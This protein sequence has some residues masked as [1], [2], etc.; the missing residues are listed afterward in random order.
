MTSIKLIITVGLLCLNICEIFGHGYMSNPPSRSSAWKKGFK[1]PINWDDNGL[2]CGGLT[3]QFSINKGKCGLCGDDYRMK[4]PRSNENGGKFGLGVIVATYNESQEINVTIV[5]SANHLGTFEFSLCP[6]EDEKSIE[7]EEC[8][9][10][11]PLKL[12]TGEDKYTLTSK[13][14]GLYEISLVLPEGLSCDHCTMRWHWRSANNWGT[15][16]DKK[17]QAMGC[18]AQETFRNCADIKIVKQASVEI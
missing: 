4:T 14:R 3:T 17:K 5:I 9:D 8:F 10:K 1:T 6:L 7:T 13:K 2:Y 18:G 12:S 11:Y 16:A 15:C